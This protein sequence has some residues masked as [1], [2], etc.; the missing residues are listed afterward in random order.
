MAERLRRVTQ[1]LV[2]PFSW[3]NVRVGSNP[4]L[5][6]F[7]CY[8]AIRTS[9]GLKLWIL[10]SNDLSRWFRGPIAYRALFSC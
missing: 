5:V 7:I 10:K 9:L 4:T 3:A 2:L 1:A 6:I 8:Q